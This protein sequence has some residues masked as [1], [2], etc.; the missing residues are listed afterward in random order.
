MGLAFTIVYIVLTILSPEQ[1]GADWAT[2]HALV[3]LAAATALFSLPNVFSG[4]A[5]KSSIQTYLLLA[6]IGAVGLSQI[7]NHW[8]GGALKAWLTFL[9]SAA[10]Y[11]FIVANVT[12]ARRLKIVALASVAACLALVAEAFCGY[13][14]GFLGET[15]VL[16][17]HFESGEAVEHVLRLR[18]VGFLNDP[19]DFSQMLIIALA[20]LFFAWRSGRTISNFVF[21]LAP[22]A[23]L[24]W[25]VYLTHSRGALIGLAVLV[26]MAGYK[27]FGKIPSLALAAMLG[28]AMMALDFTGGRAI[29]ASAGVD[30]LSLWANGLELF[31][32]APTFGVGFGN[33]ADLAG[34]TAHNSFI[35]PLAELGVIGATIWVALLV[36]T[37][38]DLNRLI[39]LREE[40]AMTPGAPNETSDVSTE[41]DEAQTVSDCSLDADLAAPFDVQ[42]IGV[43]SELPPAEYDLVEAARTEQQS[44]LANAEYESGGASA[45]A[46][47]L[48]AEPLLVTEAAPAS[49]CEPH[50]GNAET[51]P[52]GELTAESIDE[53]I[54]PDNSL[55]I[56]RLALVAFMVT[57]WFL[58]RTFDTPIY[59]V[60]G[61]ATAAVGLDPSA[62]QPHDHRRW[63]S[64]T[65]AVE[66]LL[67]IFVYLVVRLRH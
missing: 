59:L 62:S 22:A 37:T 32:S 63:I 19:N 20:L 65:L 40:P 61:L 12:T 25:A 6:F 36:I 16:N 38:M 41:E 51:G 56:V 50:V 18:G 27:R 60:L 42:T 23:V 26:L 11:F 47:P 35:L 46:F 5:L 33:F 39:A 55:V 13:Y 53:P 1:F 21:V 44:F 10:V 17:M 24:L 2:Y 34:Q 54:V 57:G 64:V 28:V 45:D 3:Y 15:F 43:R 49:G 9:P 29:D 7:A 14:A 58:S 31:K 4:S 67:I 52:A 66:A 30:R 8:L 48:P